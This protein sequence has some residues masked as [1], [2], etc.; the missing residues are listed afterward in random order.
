MVSYEAWNARSRSGS[1]T[2][3]TISFAFL[4]RF[5]SPASDRSRG[6]WRRDADVAEQNFAAWSWTRRAATRPTTTCG[7]F[8]KTSSSTRATGP[9]KRFAKIAEQKYAVG[10]ASEPDVLRAQVELTRLINRVT[11][12]T[13]LPTTLA[14]PERPSEPRRRRAA[15]LPEDPLHPRSR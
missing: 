3:T 10:R 5:P 7:W 12:E 6:P 14:Q 1:T 4:R 8:T 11:T 13:W 9:R 15:R 2:L